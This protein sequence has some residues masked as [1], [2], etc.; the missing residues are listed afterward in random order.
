MHKYMKKTFAHISQTATSQ[1][2]FTQIHVQSILSKTE[3]PSINV[4][5]KSMHEVYPLGLR[6]QFV[7]TQNQISMAYHFSP[8]VVCLKHT[9]SQLEH[10]D[11][12]AVHFRSQFD[13]KYVINV[14]FNDFKRAC[15]VRPQGAHS[16]C[17]KIENRQKSQHMAKSCCTFH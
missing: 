16:T 1:N 12:E 9:K 14:T 3:S 10:A 15:R 8:K 11:N 5:S 4:S 17:I 2:A 7:N 6:L 13:G